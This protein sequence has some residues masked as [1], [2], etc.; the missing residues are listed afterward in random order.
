VV[1]DVAFGPIR[2]DVT[3]GAQSYWPHTWVFVAERDPGELDG[4]AAAL[5]ATGRPVWG[6][7]GTVSIPLVGSLTAAPSLGVHT[8]RGFDQGYAPGGT[9]GLFLGSRRFNAI[10]FFDASV[11]LRADYRR[12]FSGERRSFSIGLQVDLFILAA[13]GAFL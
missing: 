9:A 12:S 3:C 11:G 2:A 1:R 5:A 10:S 6:A 4:I 7:G 8:A 13:F